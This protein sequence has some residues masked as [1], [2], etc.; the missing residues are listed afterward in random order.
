MNVAGLCQPSAHGSEGWGA[1]SESS[2]G[3]SGRATGI[4][5]AGG[6]RMDGRRAGVPT[7]RGGGASILVLDLGGC[8]SLPVDLEQL[9][10]GAD[11]SPL[12]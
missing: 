9:E 11:E 7:C 3:P 4:L 1:N 6:C 8:E 12:T 2:P 5:R 10:D